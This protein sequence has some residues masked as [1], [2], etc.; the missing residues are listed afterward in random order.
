MGIQYYSILHICVRKYEDL[1]SK[2]SFLGATIEQIVFVYWLCTLF[3]SRPIMIMFQ[4]QLAEV[5]PKKGKDSKFINYL[6]KLVFE[7][8]ILDCL[9][10]SSF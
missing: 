6:G 9:K 3:K 5:F 4:V 2:T 8:C 1:N 7:F 10:L